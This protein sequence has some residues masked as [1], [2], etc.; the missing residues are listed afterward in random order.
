ME[1]TPIETI[2]LQRPA[3]RPGAEPWRDGPVQTFVSNSNSNSWRDGDEAGIN[4][5]SDRPILLTPPGAGDDD[6]WQD[7]VG[8]PPLDVPAAHLALHGE[9]ARAGAPPASAPPIM[10][11]ETAHGEASLGIVLSGTPVVDLPIKFLAAL[12][13][14]CG[15]ACLFSAA[16]AS[17]R[18]CRGRVLLI[19]T[20]TLLNQ[21]WCVLHTQLT[22]ISALLKTVIVRVVRLK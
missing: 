7:D 15:G 11:V 16:V 19:L 13:A 9:Q 1:S 6:E 5:P 18:V 14:A 8:R 12:M 2:N 3:M 20:D 21:R 22:L 17:R 4:W 10:A